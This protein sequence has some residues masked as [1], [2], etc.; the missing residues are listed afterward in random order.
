MSFSADAKS[1]VARIIPNSKCCQLSELLALIKMD[2]SI[3][4]S[5]EEDID[6]YFMTENAAVARKII[7]LIKLLFDLSLDIAVQRKTK[8]K[9]NN[10]YIVRVPPQ[11]GSKK[12]LSVLGIRIKK[13]DY[14]E[15]WQNEGIKKACCRKAYLRGAF[16]GGGSVSNPEATYH[17]EIITK[18]PYHA[19]LLL[20]IMEKVGLS[21]KK[22]RRKKFEVIYLKESEQII[23]FLSIIGAHTALLE[24]E[25]QRI[26]KEVRNN[27]NRLV[28]CETANMNK[29]ID[30]G[31]RQVDN[32]KFLMDKLGDDHF[33]ETLKE[34][35]TLRLD[36]PE[37]SLK[38]LGQCLDPPM[39]KSGVNHRLR[40]LE[41]MAEG[42]KEKK[43]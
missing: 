16:L 7:K 14:K 27:V 25:N 30:T 33:P 42:Y 40:R 28:N 29:S 3:K 22:T 20:R 19:D 41:E 18:N 39:T 34:I 17:L 9:K 31:L 36:F 43:G 37:M 21:P 15:S 38:E 4:I 23:N 5:A 1:D 13:N 8:L 12:I 10:V 24:I 35:A 2:G 26:L 32:I 6:L 11:A